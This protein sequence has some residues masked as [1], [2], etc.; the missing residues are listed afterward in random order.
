ME[1][2]ARATEALETRR[3]DPRDIERWKIYCASLEQTIDSWEVQYGF[4]LLR[5]A[6]LNRS[7][8]PFRMSYQVVMSKPYAV[9]MHARLRFAHSRFH[10]G[11]S[12]DKLCVGS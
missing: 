6:L 11:I 4:L 2:I 8:P 7:N 1:E 9:T 10:F 3:V 12:L 5:Y